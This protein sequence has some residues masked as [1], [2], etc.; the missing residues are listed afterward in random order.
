M[1]VRFR[2]NLGSRDA[3]Q[4]GLD[5][6]KCLA[7][8]EL[9]VSSDTAEALQ[10]RGLAEITEKKKSVKAVPNKPAIAETK[11]PGIKGEE[12]SKSSDK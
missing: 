4:W 3:V 2:T 10:D 7:G 11:Q 6:T 9:E 8:S 5:H 12:E 1:K